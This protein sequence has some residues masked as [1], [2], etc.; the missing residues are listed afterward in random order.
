MRGLFNKAIYDQDTNAK[1]AVFELQYQVEIL[2]NKFY[3]YSLLL[4]FCFGHSSHVVET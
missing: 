1:Y 2:Y 4:I 3:K